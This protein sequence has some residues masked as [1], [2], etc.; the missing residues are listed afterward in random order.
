M[1]KTIAILEGDGIGPEIVREAVK[2]LK[3]VAEKFD[4]EFDLKTT[5]FGAAAYYSICHCP[6]V[7]GRPTRRSLAT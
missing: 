5:P 2:V 7:C 6:P 1:K 4:H 3:V